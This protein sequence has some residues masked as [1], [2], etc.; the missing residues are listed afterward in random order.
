MRTTMCKMH[1]SNKDAGYLARRLTAALR[2]CVSTPEA[3]AVQGAALARATKPPS[4]AWMAQ[5]WAT[6][7][8]Q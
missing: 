7:M 5:K 2:V 4:K 1:D 8:C 3:H 6:R